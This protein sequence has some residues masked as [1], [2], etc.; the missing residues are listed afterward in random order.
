MLGR[1][2]AI[3]VVTALLVFPYAA[4]AQATE[5][6]VR[7]AGPTMAAATAGFHVSQAADD[8][9][10]R[11]A[12]ADRAAHAGLGTDA[13]LMIVGGAGFLAG[14]IIGG[15]AGIAIAIAGAIVALYGLYMYLR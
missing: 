10:S 14:L 11:Q 1:L 7:P 13:A 5:G 3:S 4:R 2:C 9:Q 6:A 8:P 12:A 15:D